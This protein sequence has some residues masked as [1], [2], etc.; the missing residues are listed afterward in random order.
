MNK[1]TL[2]RSDSPQTNAEHTTHL[3]RG[4]DITPEQRQ[5][6]LAQVTGGSTISFNGFEMRRTGLIAPSQ[7]S[8]QDL[9]AIGQF[10][11]GVSNT[12]QLLVGDLVNLYPDQR[13]KY[14][15]LQSVTTY[16]KKSLQNFASVAKAVHISIRHGNLT[17]GHYREVAKLEYDEQKHVLQVASD[18]SDDGM[19]IA[20]MKAYMR[21]QRMIEAPINTGGDWREQLTTLANTQLRRAHKMDA[22]DRSVLAEFHR[23][24]AQEIDA[25]E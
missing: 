13:H 9:D 5:T 10:L 6:A 14:D 15:H 20:Q 2:I 21:K 4:A 11:G 17:F 12:L 22:D 23:R 8:P 7:F 19:T 16:S 25:I 1:R 24:L 18:F 3:T